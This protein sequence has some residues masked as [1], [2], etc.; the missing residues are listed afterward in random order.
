[1]EGLIS[2]VDVDK[3]PGVWTSMVNNYMEFIWNRTT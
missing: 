3:I 2:A 1:M